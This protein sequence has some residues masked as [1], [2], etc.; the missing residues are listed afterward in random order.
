MNF[1]NS[2]QHSSEMR[3]V[4]TKNSKTDDKTILDFHKNVDVHMKCHFSQDLSVIYIRDSLSSHLRSDDLTHT[5]DKKYENHQQTCCHSKQMFSKYFRNLSR[6]VRVD[7]RNRNTRLFHRFTFELI[8]KTCAISYV[9][10]KHVVDDSQKM[11]QNNAQIEHESRSISH[12]QKDF[13]R[14]QTRMNEIVIVHELTIFDKRHD[15]FMNESN[16][17]RSR[18]LKISSTTKKKNKR[19]S[20]RS[21]KTKMKNLM[22]HRV[23]VDFNSDKEY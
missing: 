10:R 19:S 11:R 8:T 17:I 22:R 13:K 15:R 5:Q 16:T 3:F 23:H 6:H 4:H 20:C 2:D 9:N 12:T 18:T 1:E 7:L 14:A 21:L